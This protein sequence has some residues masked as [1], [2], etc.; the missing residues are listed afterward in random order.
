[1]VRAFGFGNIGM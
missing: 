1:M